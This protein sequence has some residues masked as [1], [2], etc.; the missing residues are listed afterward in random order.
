MWFLLLSLSCFLPP[1]FCLSPRTQ[2]FLPLVVRFR[3]LLHGAYFCFPREILVFSSQLFALLSSYLKISHLHIAGLSHGLPAPIH[4]RILLMEVTDMKKQ[5]IRRAL[6]LGLLTCASVLT[7]S[8]ISPGEAQLENI[9]PLCTNATLIGSYA[10]SRT[11]TFVF[12][13]AVAANGV[14][15]LD[16]QGNLFGSDT[17]SINGRISQRDFKGAYEVRADCTGEAKFAFSDREGVMIEFQIVDREKE[18]RFIQT[19]TGTVVTGSAKRMRDP[20]QL[21]PE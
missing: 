15:T 18:F 9:R 12:L 20:F 21:L 13:G 10:Y 8:G 14:I 1:I 3:L 7:L 19:D 16:G 11:G 6:L 5:Q 2:H 4:G 17:A